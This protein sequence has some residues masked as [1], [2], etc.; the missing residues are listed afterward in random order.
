[1][2]VY[3]T[4]IILT[5]QRRADQLSMHS[6]QQ[7]LKLTM[8][9]EQKVAKVIALLEEGRQ[10]NPMLKNRLDREALAMAQPADPEHLLQPVTV[11]AAGDLETQSGD[12]T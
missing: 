8:L 3:V 11:L 5:T 2:A 10:D 7:I 12:E 4:L 9:T 6:S 1:M